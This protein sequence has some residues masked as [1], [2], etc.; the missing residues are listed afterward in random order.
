MFLYLRLYFFFFFFSYFSFWER[1]SLKYRRCTSSITVSCPWVCGWAW[2]SPP[3]RLFVDEHFGLDENIIVFRFQ[4]EFNFL[5][6]NIT[7]QVAIV[8]FS[9]CWI[10]S[11]ILSCTSTTCSQLWDQNTKNTFG[12]KNT[13]LHS[14]WWAKT[15]F[16]LKN[17]YNYNM[18]L[19]YNSK[20]VV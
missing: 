3:V 4:I 11:Y 5:A 16:Q 13:W 19:F 12:G 8:H 20:S 9:P 14:K 1:N 17:Y 2:N 6:F 18:Y 10:L 15:A 7:F